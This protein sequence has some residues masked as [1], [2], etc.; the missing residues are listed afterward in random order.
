MLFDDAFLLETDAGG[1]RA[2]VAAAAAGAGAGARLM[3][4]EGWG[5][6]RPETFA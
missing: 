5:F 2:R 4:H 6:S 1:G 3:A